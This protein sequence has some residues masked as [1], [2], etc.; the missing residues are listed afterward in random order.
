MNCERFEERMADYLAGRSSPELDAHLEACADCRAEAA[1]LREIWRNLGLIGTAQ[2]SRAL[3]GR[4]YQS[5]EAYQHGRE[6]A[7]PR[8][9]AWF[10]LPVFQ[11]AGA[12]LLLVV[13]VVAGYSLAGSNR[14]DV[15]M[16]RLEGEVHNMRQ[17]VTLAL[18]QQQS[19][20]ERLRGVDWGTRVENPDTQVL[21]ALLY[22]LD[23][24][25]NVNVRLA[26]VDA[27]RKFSQ[28]PM[29]RRSLNQSLVRQE[30]PLVQVALI[31]LFV[32]LR[33]RD[34]APRLRSLI[35]SADINPEVKERAQ[36]GLEQLR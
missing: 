27:L 18:L 36:Q 4:F 32:G 11:L 1:R 24:D 19:P 14:Q 28:V 23:H 20:S 22:T 5:L 21:S 26:A 16:A 17:M 12:A 10:R 34:A 3:R 9:L 35:D 25:T 33:A 6:T 2:P 31:D 15:E 7:A 29:V 13:G 30:S 8:R